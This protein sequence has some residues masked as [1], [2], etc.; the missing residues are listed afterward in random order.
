MTKK[1]KLHVF[2]IAFLS[3]HVHS[4]QGGKIQ[5]LSFY[6]LATLNSIQ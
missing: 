6:E 2:N 1:Y 4:K 3:N 5:F